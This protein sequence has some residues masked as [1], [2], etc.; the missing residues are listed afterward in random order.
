MR[1]TL[2]LM[3]AL[4][5]VAASAQERRVILDGEQMTATVT[6]D[7]IEIR[8][9]SPPVALRE[10]GVTPDTLLVRG[11]WEGGIFIG[12]AFVFAP[13]CPPLAYPVRGMV[14]QVGN[15][16]VL[17]PAPSAIKDCQAESLTW[18]ASSILQFELPV[19]RA[20]PE[21][22]PQ[23]KAKPKAKPK[24]KPAPKP[25]PAAPAPQVRQP[26]ENQWQWRW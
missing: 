15:L 18:N 5:S 25:R 21:R 12:E 17:G 26:W 16:L 8:Y 24:P 3:F 6:G 9:V 4:W 13:A 22:K 23:V 2:L 7:R 20:V 14:D 10:L 11:Q 1:C 19:S